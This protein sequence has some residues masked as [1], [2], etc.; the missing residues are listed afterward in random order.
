MSY[1][2]AGIK[3]GGSAQASVN[4]LLGRRKGEAFAIR[5]CIATALVIGGRGQGRKVAVVGRELGG[6]DAVRGGGAA[7]GAVEAGHLADLRRVEVEE[8][9]RHAAL[10][11][12]AEG[13]LPPL[14]V[15]AQDARPRRPHLRPNHRLGKG[16]ELGIGRP[17]PSESLLLNQKIRTS[18]EAPKQFTAGMAPTEFVRGTAFSRGQLQLPCEFGLRL[19]DSGRILQSAP[20]FKIRTEQLLPTNRQFALYARERGCTSPNRTPNAPN[21]QQLCPQSALK[22]EK[23][24]E[25]ELECSRSR[26]QIEAR[27]FVVMERGRRGR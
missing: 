15:R 18:Q 19:P 14:S 11:H 26:P 21:I 5:I 25:K 7:E 8:H 27:S 2:C 9:R 16:V 6:P 22:T 23:F 20:P 10:R 24:T 4:F 17:R 13:R 1:L 12:V 3:E